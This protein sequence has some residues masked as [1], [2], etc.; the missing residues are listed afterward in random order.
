MKILINYFKRRPKDMARNRV[1]IQQQLEGCRALLKEAV[2]KVDEAYADVTSTL[3]QRAALEATVKDLKNRV[4]KYENDLKE[5][6]DEAA[7]NFEL[8][9]SI[10]NARNSGDE[11]IEAKA[12]LIRAAMKKEKVSQRVLNSLGEGSG[13]GNG[14][15]LLPT[16]LMTEL[17]TAPFAVNPL[18]GISTM[19]N[20]TNLEIPKL[21]FTLDDDDF[22]TSN[23]ATAKE[24]KLSA[25]K[26]KFER[27][28]FR[29]YA[30]IT[31]A[32]LR[33]S[34]VNLVGYVENALRSGMAKKEK[35]LAFAVGTSNPET[36][37]YNKT[38]SSYDI[39]AITKE[40]KYLAI[41][42]ALADLEDDY[43]DKAK[44]VMRRSDYFDIIEALA[45]GN[46]TL[47][48]AQPESVLGA[49]VIFCDL[50][51]IPVVGDFSYSHFNYDLDATYESDK[52]IRTGITSFVLT[53]YLDHKIKMKSAFRLALVQGE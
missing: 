31:D 4:E 49:P 40:S 48:Q 52:N 18:R 34:N 43:A 30:D 20:I 47:Y 13:N 12:E 14:E 23:S 32:V 2:N 53:G 5:L 25:S 24:M 10:R 9:N 33:G 29:V 16:T 36:S 38:G 3:E 11:K 37:F 44:I 46:A 8:E 7:K 50:A 39:T 21:A 19:T 22:L 26:I 1:K 42:A 17:V 51:T 41:K 15:N 35:K 6:D 28:D 27:K 45:N